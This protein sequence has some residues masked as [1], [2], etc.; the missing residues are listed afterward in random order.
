MPEAV[1]YSRDC[2]GDARAGT[3]LSHHF[4][5]EQR[6]ARYIAL[7]AAAVLLVI[8]V[9]LIASP[10]LRLNVAEALNAV[11]DGEREELF[12][13]ATGLELVVLIE[14]VPVEY[15]L[16]LRRYTAVYVAERTPDAI[17]LHDL[18]MGTTVTVPLTRYDRF[19]VAADRSA[20]LVVDEAANPDRAVLVTVA[21]GVVRALPPGE[22]DPGI[23]GDWRADIFAGIAGCN[24]VSPSGAWVACA[25][26]SPRVFGDWELYIH[27]AGRS[28]DKTF[29]LRGLGTTPVLGWAADESA[30][31]LQNENG[32]IEVPLDL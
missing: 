17:L 21:T 25:T 10:G 32:V 26:S 11:P 24:A 3:P 16:P 31:Y 30:V 19:S 8:F 18:S 13:G 20:I 9:P 15:S 5:R 7:V 4:K 12:P 29:I 6:K 23:P 28:K 22:T 1:S 27:P 2:I 14:E